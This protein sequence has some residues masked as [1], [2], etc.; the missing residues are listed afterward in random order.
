MYVLTHF[1]SVVFGDSLEGLETYLVV[2]S[3]CQKGGF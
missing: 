3:V 1:T 2:I